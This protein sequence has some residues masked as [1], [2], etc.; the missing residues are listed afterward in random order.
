M[1]RKRRAQIQRYQK[2]NKDT[3][4]NKPT[5]RRTNSNKKSGAGNRGK[6][7]EDGGDAL[8]GYS[9]CKTCLHKQPQSG[10]I[11]IEPDWV[12]SG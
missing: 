7:F 12:H 6:K 2:L 10:P 5:I 1:L 8:P 9:P 3:G 11:K 4:D